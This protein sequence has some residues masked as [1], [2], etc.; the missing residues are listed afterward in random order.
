[1]TTTDFPATAPKGVEQ[2]V[3]DPGTPSNRGDLF[4]P[5]PPA[6]N[7]VDDVPTVASRFAVCNADLLVTLDDR[8]FSP[9]SRWYVPVKRAFDIVGALLLLLLL[10]PL[11]VAAVVATK[12]YSPGPAFYCQRRLGR[13]GKQFTIIKIRTMVVDAEKRSGAVWSTGNRDSRV[14]RVGHLLR[15]THIDEFPQLF[16]VLRGDMSLI[17][18]RPERPEIVAKLEDAV[19]CYKERLR[20][21]P[22]IA[23]LAQCKLPPDSCL[24]NVWDKVYLDIYYV[25]FMG[26]I[27][28]AKIFFKTGYIFASSAIR[29]IYRKLRLPSAGKVE[30][31]LTTI[32]ES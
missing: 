24:D 30:R 6:P 2:L 4:G 28:D 22:G 16:N 14:T 10:S 11:I 32:L 19:P 12:I 9:L 29:A 13:G 23:G 18:P 27:L 26:P 3:S 15:D 21:K 8:E 31:R 17:G 5:V 1:M 7:R 25:S 20:V